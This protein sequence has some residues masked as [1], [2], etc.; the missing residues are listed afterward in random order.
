MR[1]IHGS[2]AGLPAL[3]TEAGEEQSV[4]GDREARGALDIP[5]RLLHGT[6]RNSGD[7]A[8][9][10]AADMLM[11]AVHSLEPSLAVA[12]LD[13]GDEPFAFPMREGAEHRREVGRHT[14]TTELG[15]DVLD[16]PVVPGAAGQHL[17]DG[18]ADVAGSCHG[19]L[20]YE[21]Y[22]LLAKYG[23]PA[24]TRGS[25]RSAATR[26][27]SIRPPMRWS[28]IELAPNPPARPA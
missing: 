24:H 26:V 18:V 14:P 23:S 5:P 9:R 19:R 4:T 22:N 13:T 12:E 25:T 3:G 11:V 17:A 28:L 21:I 15:E 6:V 1:S 27:G 10:V 7:G 16:R 20:A 2:C 8:A